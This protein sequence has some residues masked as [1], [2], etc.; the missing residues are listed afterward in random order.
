MS[1][2]W[3][4]KTRRLTANGIGRCSIGRAR[5]VPIRPQPTW[6]GLRFR[7]GM[8]FRVGVGVR[9]GVWVRARVRVRV[10]VRV[11]LRV[12]VRAGGLPS[13]KPH[14]TSGASRTA[15]LPT[16]RPPKTPC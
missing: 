2:R 9:L 11:G 6:V 4:H 1:V 10:R 14:P 3:E 12:R 15:P 13:H 7:V 8:G 16:A 5:P